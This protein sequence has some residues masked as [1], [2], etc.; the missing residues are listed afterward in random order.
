MRKKLKKRSGISVKNKSSSSWIWY[1]FFVLLVLVIG[2]FL[3]RGITGNVVSDTKTWTIVSGIVANRF[4]VGGTGVRYYNFTLPYNVNLTKVRM[5]YYDGSTECRAIVQRLNNGQW[6][7]VSPLADLNEKG[8]WVDQF[9]Y[10]NSIGLNFRLFFSSDPNELCKNLQVSQVEV[11]YT[12]TP[13]CAGKCGGVS[14]G[15]GGTCLFE[16]GCTAGQVCKSD[17]TCCTKSYSPLPTSFCYN[18]SVSVSNGCGG[19]EMKNGTLSCATGQICNSSNVCACIP[20]ASSACTGKCG[21][22]SNGCGGELVCGGC[23]EGEFC[24]NNICTTDNS[25]SGD[26]Y[27]CYNGTKPSQSD[28]YEELDCSSFGSNF[29]CYSCNFGYGWNITGKVCEANCSVRPGCGASFTNASTVSGFCSSGG[30]FKCDS[31]FEWNGT[32]CILKQCSSNPGCLNISLLANSNKIVDR[33]CS[34]GS[35][36]SCTSGYTWRNSSFSCVVRSSSGWSNITFTSSDFLAGATKTFSIS[37][38]AYFTFNSHLYWMGLISVD[39]DELTANVTI[40]SIINKTLDLDEETKVDLNRDGILDISLTLK[41][42]DVG[43]ADISVLKLA[44]V[45]T[46]SSCG[47]GTCNVNESCS[48]CVSDCG[49]CVPLGSVCGNDICESDESCSSCSRD[50]DSCDD[51]SK[52]INWL[53]WVIGGLVIL[54]IIVVLAILF[55]TRKKQEPL[56]I[57]PVVQQQRPVY[58]QSSQ[59]LR[60][61]VPPVQVRRPV[62]SIERKIFPSTVDSDA[63][64]VEEIRKQI[65]IGNQ[66]VK[67]GK[68]LPAKA[69]YSQISKLYSQLKAPNNTLYSE[70]VVFYNKVAK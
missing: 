16:E 3:Y 9:W 1:L 66:Y 55:T 37:D 13:N 20:L 41:D 27:F 7:N 32:K 54:I 50:C 2:F 62:Q 56:K 65:S 17:N 8:Q 18:T 10:P 24:V 47:D 33:F 21:N 68:V 44:Q 60:A 43:T 39:L 53:V 25:C 28:D 49:A 67:D 61:V 6:G 23:D 30:C 12:C 4:G 36:F 52:P 51:E 70:I 58:S 34:V 59:P 31:D 35:C 15:C 42:L 45:S 19:T 40:Y 22:I 38:R 46:G 29:N 69:V 5:H 57:A 26:G 14:D 63:K 48:S 64:V 11:W